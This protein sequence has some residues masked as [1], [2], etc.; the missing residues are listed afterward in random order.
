[1]N[2]NMLCMCRGRLTVLSGFLTLRDIPEEIGFRQG[3]FF[4]KTLIHV[5]SR[6]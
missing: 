5:W 2:G 4:D 3:T 1:M 6:S